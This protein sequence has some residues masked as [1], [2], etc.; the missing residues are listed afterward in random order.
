MHAPPP[1]EERDQRNLAVL[2]AVLPDLRLLRALIARGIDLN[3]AHA[4]MT[5]LLAA[6]RDSWHGR[7]DAVM[8][9]LANGADPRAVDNDGNTALHHAARSSDPGVAALLR[10]AAAE[11]DA[12]N[13]DGLSPLGIACAA[14]NWRLAKFLLERGA[15]PEPAGGQPALLA[16]AGTE[17]DDAAGV[18]LLLKQK[19][20]VDARDAQGR[21]A[22]H[23]AAYAGHIEIVEALL[24]AGADA[25][26][27]D[28]LARTPLLEAARGGHLDVLE[29]LLAQLPKGGDERSRRRR[30]ARSRRTHARGDVGARH[31]GADRAPA[32]P[33]PGCRTRA[34][35]TTSARSI[36]PPKPDAGRWSRP[37]IAPIRCR[38]RCAAWTLK[39]G[40]R[41]MRRCPIARP[42]HC[43]AKACTNVAA[44]NSPVSRSCSARSNSGAL[45]HD[46]PPLPAPSRSNVCCCGAP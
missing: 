6:T 21:S 27:V 22:L 12:L 38:R 30:R 32:R 15:K 7:P 11:V 16:A 37:S 26:A 9:L 5:P 2:A 35:S 19:A 40:T 36:A 23:E 1:A 28:R 18:V 43:C 3:T 13:V 14:G 31:A 42:P 25:A 41:R 39:A 45:L 34:T 24:G 10:D 44:P 4:G 46:E 17:E 29:R 8:T 20:K 33:G